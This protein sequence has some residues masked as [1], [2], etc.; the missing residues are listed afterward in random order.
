MRRGDEW[1]ERRNSLNV[2]MSILVTFVLVLV[3]IY[4]WT[5]KRK[6]LIY[7]LQKMRRKRM[8]DLQRNLF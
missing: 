8:T 5:M 6:C 3:A 2:S 1:D 4:V 7:Y